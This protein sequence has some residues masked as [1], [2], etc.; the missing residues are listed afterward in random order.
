MENKDIFVDLRQ[1]NSGVYLKLTERSGKSRNTILI[2][3]SGIV[4]L[5]NVLEEVS[6]ISSKNPQIRFEFEL[7]LMMFHSSNVYFLHSVE[8]KNRIATDPAVV[9]RSVYVSGLAWSTEDTALEQHFSQIGPV[10]SAVVLRKS[11]GGKS[12]SLGC[13]VV[14]FQ[15]STDAARAVAELNDSELDGRTLKCRED[16]TVDE[17]ITQKKEDT[18]TPDPYK[19]FVSSLFWETSFESLLDFGGKVGKIANI[20]MLKTKS[21]RS[22]GQA[23]IEYTEPKAALAAIEQLDKQ[24]IDGRQVT[25]REYYND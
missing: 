22:L 8:R 18:R 15:S 1:N 11:R 12:I 7:I 13:G 24:V 5:K 10:A 20:E 19:V 9:N 3:A 6:A 16:R 25:V 23:I 4:R 14:E 17:D 2:P 21:G